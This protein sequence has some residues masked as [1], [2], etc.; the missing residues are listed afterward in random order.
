MQPS[1]MGEYALPL[2]DG[3]HFEHGS[4]EQLRPLPEPVHTSSC[5]PSV[6]HL[7]PMKQW[8]VVSGALHVNLP[9]SVEGSHFLHP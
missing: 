4:G 5:A 8:E 2:T 3:M 7:S 9:A 1:V 6:M